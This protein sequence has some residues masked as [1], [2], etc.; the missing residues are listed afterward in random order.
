MATRRFCAQVGERDTMLASLYAK[1]YV[2]LKMKRGFNGTGSR[3]RGPCRYS[4]AS[5]NPNKDNLR[6]SCDAN[7]RNNPL[8]PMCKARNGERLPV[9]GKHGKFGNGSGE[10]LASISA[11]HAQCRNVPCT[12]Q[13]QPMCHSNGQPR[14][15][16]RCLQGEQATRSSRNLLSKASRALALLNRQ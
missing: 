16:P 1:C 2:A 8:A 3:R 12:L 7:I 6:S 9:S 13:I 5:K 14:Q 11:K 10:L 15:T 4:T